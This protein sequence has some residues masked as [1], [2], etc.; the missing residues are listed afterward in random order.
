MEVEMEDDVLR[1]TRRSLHAVAELVIAGPQYRAHGTIKLRAV[2]GGFGAVLMPVRVEGGEL[3]WE[4]GR[5]PLDRSCRDLATAAGLDAGAPGNYPDASG[6]DPDEPIAVDVAAADLIADWYARGDEALRGFAPDQA[7]VLWPE[8]FDLGISVDEVNY[9]VSPGDAG[10]PRPYAYVGPWSPREGAFWNAPFG[11][12]RWADEL[13][14]AAALL[15]F[16]TEGRSRAH[17]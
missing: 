5:M 14:D 7:R 12:M 16:L 3:V 10:Y 6:V 4:G 17:R 9:G 1:A 13:P 15:D 2:P 8:H 11:A